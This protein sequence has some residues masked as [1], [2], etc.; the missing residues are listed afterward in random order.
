[1]KKLM[2]VDDN[3]QDMESLAR[4]LRENGFS[5]TEIVDDAGDPDLRAVTGEV[6]SV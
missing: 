1:M 3:G 2:I 5:A 6:G 4:L